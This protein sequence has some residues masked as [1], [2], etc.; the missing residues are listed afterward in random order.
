MAQGQKVFAR[1]DARV[2]LDADFR[3]GRKSEALF[4]VAKKIFE[5]R[6]RRVGRR[7]AAPVELDDFA[8]AGNRPRD[9]RDLFLQDFEVGKRDALVLLDDDVASAE[10]A[11][12]FAEGKMHVERYRGKRGISGR[13]HLLEV[14]RLERVVPHR[15]GRI[16]GIARA[17]AVV[18]REELF[19]DVEFASGFFETR[20]RNH[21]AGLLVYSSRRRRNAPDHSLART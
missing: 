13:V 3:V 11:Q 9:P 16:T 8:F 20:M 6:G 2:D 21:R 10:Q 4:A 7:P 17:G 1:G 12:A 15:S 5:L 19:A 14:G 18:A